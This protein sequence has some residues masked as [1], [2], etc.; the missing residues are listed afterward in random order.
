M[1]QDRRISAKDRLNIKPPTKCRQQ[2]YARFG[3]TDHT[4]KKSIAL[5]MATGTLLLAGCTTYHHTSTA[6]EYEIIERADNVALQTALNKAADDG[7]VFVSTAAQGSN[8][9]VYAVMKRA[10]K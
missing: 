4:M 9:G 8:S 2:P 3:V 1:K 6:W 10:K 5:I 7:W